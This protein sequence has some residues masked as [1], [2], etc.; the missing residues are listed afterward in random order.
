[1]DKRT[2]GGVK[3]TEERKRRSDRRQEL[4]RARAELEEIRFALDE[5]WQSFNRSTDP[6][7][8]EAYIFEINALRSRYDH[9]F[10]Q[11]KSLAL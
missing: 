11:L 8:T 3:L 2:F 7:L 1:M 10:K 4:L 6:A 9:V 5:S